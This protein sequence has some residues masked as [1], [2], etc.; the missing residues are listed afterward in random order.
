MMRNPY[1]CIVIVTG[2]GLAG[3]I[4]LA[5]IILLAYAGRPVPDSLTAVV[6]AAL[7]SLSSFLVMPPRGSAGGGTEPTSAPTSAPKEIRA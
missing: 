7:G 1:L 5:G 6:A 4:G 3:T 2:L